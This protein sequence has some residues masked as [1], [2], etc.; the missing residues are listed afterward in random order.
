MGFGHWSSSTLVEALCQRLD[1]TISPRYTTLTPV[2]ALGYGLCIDS[3]HPTSQ[4][5]FEALNW[6]DGVVIIDEPNRYSGTGWILVPVVKT[7]GYSQ[8]VEDP[9]AEYFGRRGSSLSRRC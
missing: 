1:S 8:V 2:P 4:A 3:L 7:G 9:N 5:H 6:S